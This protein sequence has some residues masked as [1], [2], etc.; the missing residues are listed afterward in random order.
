M[1]KRLWNE[2]NQLQ[3]ERKEVI[4]TTHHNP[5][6]YFISKKI[7]LINYAHDLISIMK[8]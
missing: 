3:Y 5:L 2:E 6:K 8:S 4:F 1:S 7:K